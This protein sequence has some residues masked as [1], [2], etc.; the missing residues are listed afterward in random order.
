MG[1]YPHNLHFLW[2]AAT[3]SGQEE[4]AIQTA[5]KVADKIPAQEAANNFNAQ[6][7]LSVPLQCYVRFGKWN[8]ILTTPP[9]DTSLDLVNMYWHYARSIA[10]TKSGK[11]NKAADEVNDLNTLVHHVK[12]EWRKNGETDSAHST[13]SNLYQILSLIPQ[14]EH[15][16]ARGDYMRGEYLLRK[17]IRC[18]DQLPYNEPPEWHHPI[19]QILGAHLQDIGYYERAA[20]L[21]KEDLTKLPDNGW[22][23]FGLLQCKKAIHD[24][25]IVDTNSKF[26]ESWQHADFNLTRASF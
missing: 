3:L 26:K 23:L 11:L 22:S 13:K 14:A 1:Y 19:R 25:S 24:L 20:H 2:M 17:A 4:L 5:L 12:S 9:P 8:E 16:F 21:F 10:F 7:F 15:A 18:E 6:N